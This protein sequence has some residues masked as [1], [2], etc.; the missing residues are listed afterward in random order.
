MAPTGAFGRYLRVRS[1]LLWLGHTE[2][3]PRERAGKVARCLDTRCKSGRVG[4]DRFVGHF[5]TTLV[6]F[7]Q[8]TE[9]TGL[10]LNHSLEPIYLRLR[11]LVSACAAL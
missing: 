10:A 9:V 8:S 4:I 7:A 5:Q 1:A 3:S 2:R 11:S 6:G